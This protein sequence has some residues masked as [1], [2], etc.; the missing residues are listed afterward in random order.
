MSELKPCP[1]CGS[2]SVFM[3]GG[4]YCVQCG[5]CGAEGPWN[6]D[7]PKV[8]IDAWNRRAPASEGEQK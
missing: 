2:D 4:S 1:F 6:D 3:L 5:N 8:A 7:D